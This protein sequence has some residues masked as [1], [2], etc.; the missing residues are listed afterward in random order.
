[1]FGFG[2]KDK[3]AE[4]PE[5]AGNEASWE[6]RGH[7]IVYSVL[8]KGTPLLALHGVNASAGAFELRHNLEPLAS[9]YRVY[10]PDMPGFGRSERKRLRYTAEMYIEFIADFARYIAQKEQQAPAVWACSLMAAHTI[11]AV[12]RTPEAFGPLLL[13]SPTGLE[14]LNFGPG[15]K[16]LRV[17]KILFGPI[18]SVLFRLLTSR[19]STRRFL[20]RDAYYDPNYITDEIIEQYHQSARQPNAKYAPISFI[21]FGLNHSVK[22]EWP[23]IQQPTL[24]IWGR[25][26]MI[27]PL[28]TAALF[29]KE[30]PGTEL[31]VI[32]QARLAV[33]DEQADQF[34]ALALEWFSRHT[35]KTKEPVGSRAA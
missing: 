31:R 5:L 21:T 23:T 27:T 11:G 19:R 30:R 4:L 18:G 29:L 8:G 28:S 33:Y 3:I 26:A 9:Q 24:I 34:N 32:E 35:R 10:A 6:W 17:Y 14:K 13:V 12:T 15:K 16:A 20:G 25:E 1:M 22:E 2:K 7:K